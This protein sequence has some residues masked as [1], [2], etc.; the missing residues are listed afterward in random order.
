MTQIRVPIS[1]CVRHFGDYNTKNA[2]TIVAQP[3]TDWVENVTK[4]TRLRKQLNSTVES[5]ASVI[6][7]TPHPSGTLTISWC[8]T[9]INIV[10]RRDICGI[11]PEE[12][13]GGERLFCIH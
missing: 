12:D 11:P 8:A 9:M 10:Q 5:E 4:N 3:E 2:F 6:Q 7:S 1:K 13:W